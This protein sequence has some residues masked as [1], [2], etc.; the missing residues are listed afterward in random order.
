MKL[1]IL[2]FALAVA[3]ALANTNPGTLSHRTRDE[4]SERKDHLRKVAAR[5]E[6]PHESTGSAID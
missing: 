4:K 5:S 1:G 3:P 6:S 2:A